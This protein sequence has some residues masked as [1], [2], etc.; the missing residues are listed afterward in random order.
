MGKSFL[1]PVSVSRGEKALT[2]LIRYNGAAA[3][4]PPGHAMHRP[5]AREG[6]PD[7]TR[8]KPGQ[9]RPENR[10]FRQGGRRAGQAPSRYGSTSKNPINLINT[11]CCSS[12]RLSLRSRPSGLPTPRRPAKFST[13]PF[14]PDS[15]GKQRKRDRRPRPRRLP[16]GAGKGPAQ[17]KSCAR[18]FKSRYRPRR[19]AMGGVLANL[20]RA[21]RQQPQ[22]DLLRVVVRSPPQPHFRRPASAQCPFS[23]RAG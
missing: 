3:S 9:D 11:I 4:S 2:A 7:K 18:R 1:A 17:T 16:P 8:Q 6:K 15:D 20:V 13:R 12:F 21:G 23:D 22:R 19:S 14:L 5:V 10:R